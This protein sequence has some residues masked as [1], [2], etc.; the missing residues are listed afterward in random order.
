[1]DGLKACIDQSN[2][3]TPRFNRTLLEYAAFRDFLPDPARPV[4]PKDFIRR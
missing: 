3:Y 4:H 2:P 1:M